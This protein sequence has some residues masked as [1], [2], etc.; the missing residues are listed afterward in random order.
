MRRNSLGARN[1]IAEGIKILSD[2]N[3]RKC[4]GVCGKG[5]LEVEVGRFRSRL[6]I[7]VNVDTCVPVLL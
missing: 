2:T 7:P 5:F 3:V 6:W 1:L 4:V